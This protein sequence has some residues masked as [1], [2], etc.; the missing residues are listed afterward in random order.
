MRGR[1]LIGVERLMT[2]RLVTERRK[3]R[4][5]VFGSVV[6]QKPLLRLAPE[7]EATF[8]AGVKVPASVPCDIQ[9]AITGIRTTGWCVGQ[10]RTS[11]VSLPRDDRSPEPSA[12]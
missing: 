7:E 9:I 2:T 3:P 10:W 12:D 11:L 8:S 6:S 4:R 5:V 1:E